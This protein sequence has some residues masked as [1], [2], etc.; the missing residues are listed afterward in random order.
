MR[1]LHFCPVRIGR[2][3]VW[4]ARL[5]RQME[6]LGIL[7]EI[8]GRDRRRVY[9]HERYFALFNDAVVGAG[10]IASDRFVGP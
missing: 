5:A 2:W 10:S 7:S 6:A 4:T 8:S 1:C 9:L 3:V